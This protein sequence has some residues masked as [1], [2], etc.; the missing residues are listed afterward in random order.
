MRTT[1][2]GGRQHHGPT[3]DRADVRRRQTIQVVTV[4]DGQQAIEKMAALRPDIVLAGTTL[5]QV[6]GYDLAK[7]VRGKAE[8]QRRAGAVVER[9]VRNGG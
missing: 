8:L 4:A 2:A 6:S 1:P 5:P 9:R 3:G 7:F